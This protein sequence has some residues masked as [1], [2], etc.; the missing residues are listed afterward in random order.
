MKRDY[1]DRPIVGVGA[2]IVQ[3]GR[4]LVIRRLAEP[5]K[6]EWSI[7][8]G[9]LELGEEL[10]KGVA[11]EAKEETGLAVEVD[12]VLDVFDAIYPDPSGRL[13]YHY[14]LIDFLCY[15]VAGEASAGSDAEDLQ[16]VTGEELE[17]LRLRPMTLGV[18]R[19]GLEKA[20]DH[21]ACRS[22]K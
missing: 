4:V 15:P 17:S 18:I 5:L 16:W 14:V 6:G 9:M 12:E 3:E 10:R 22:R 19:K 8:G 2:V 13:Q 21:K 11:R 7:P 1:P 20:R